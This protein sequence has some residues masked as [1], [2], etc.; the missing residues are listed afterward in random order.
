MWACRFGAVAVKREGMLGDIESPF[1]RDFLLPFFDLFVV[2]FFHPATIK[3]DQVVVMRTL[4]KL[5]HGFAS[6]EVIAV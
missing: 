3:A 2:K 6:F 1:I 5:K 4:I